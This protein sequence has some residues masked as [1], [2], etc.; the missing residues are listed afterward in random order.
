MGIHADHGKSLQ[1]YVMTSNQTMANISTMGSSSPSMA[2][3]SWILLW[4]AAAML[5]VRD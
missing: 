3:A 5:I 4:V 1:V 2:V